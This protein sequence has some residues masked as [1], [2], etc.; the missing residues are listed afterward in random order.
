[1]RGQMTLG[2]LIEAL[3]KCDPEAEAR[4]DFGYFCPSFCVSYRGYYDEL[5]ISYERGTWPKVSAVLAE[6]GAAL[7]NEFEGY[8][9]GVYR[10]A[11]HTPVWVANYGESPGVAVVEVK[12]GRGTVIIC[13]EH[14]D[15]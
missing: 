14:I 13:T 4:F 10:M 11:G 8:K 12:N 6:L 1:M 2:A 5:A 3:R 7:Q 15:D 9:G